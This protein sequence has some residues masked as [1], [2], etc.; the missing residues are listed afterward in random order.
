MLS[1][2]DERGLTS[3]PADIHYELGESSGVIRPRSPSL[4][5]EERLS[6]VG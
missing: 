2:A 6:P 3:V 1:L 4:L 5:T